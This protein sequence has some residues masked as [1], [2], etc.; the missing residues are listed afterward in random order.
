MFQISKIILKVCKTW[1]LYLHIFSSHAVLHSTSN[2]ADFKKHKINFMLYHWSWISLDGKWRHISAHYE[3][4]AIGFLV[5]FSIE[6][7]FTK[8]SSP[9]SFI[10]NWDITLSPG[11]HIFWPQLKYTR[12][13]TWGRLSLH[14]STLSELPVIR[15]RLDFLSEVTHS[16]E[17]PA[18]SY[19]HTHTQN[20]ES[21]VTL[22]WK[23]FKAELMISF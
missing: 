4:I 10:S 16:N 7:T 19:T 22:C 8:L 14:V 12:L 20:Q 2:C 5:L 11:I 15:L 23:M 6:A 3:V 18:S 1:H 21:K 17:S 13:S 9:L